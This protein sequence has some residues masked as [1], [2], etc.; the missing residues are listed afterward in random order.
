M[1]TTNYDQP[2]FYRFDS[3]DVLV[4]T[5][6]PDNS[7]TYTVSYIANVPTNQAPGV[8]ATTITYVCTGTF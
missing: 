3:N 2:N 5:T 1:P 6:Q 7:R 4:S 8:Y